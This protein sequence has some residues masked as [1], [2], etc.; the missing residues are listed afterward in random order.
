ML[1]PSVLVLTTLVFQIG[2]YSVPLLGRDWAQ[3]D[4]SVLPLDLL[5]QLRE[6]ERRGPVGTPIFNDMLFG[7]FLIYYTPGLRVF[8]DDRCE[9]HGDKGLG[10]YV[11]A[12]RDNPAQIEAWADQ[13]GFKSALIRTDS[14]FDHYFQRASG[15]SMVRR[16]EA[17]TLYQRSVKIVQRD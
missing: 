8:I 10:E 11:Q 17:A 5:P 9:L 1:V 2:S 7:G 12:L 14:A 3:L 4:R 15:W 6:L 16:T 13:Y